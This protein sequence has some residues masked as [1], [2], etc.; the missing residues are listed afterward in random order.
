MYL[1]LLQYA[2]TVHGQ[3]DLG[4]LLIIPR[5]FVFLDDLLLSTP[6]MLGRVGRRQMPFDIGCTGDQ[7]D[8]VQVDDLSQ[9]SQPLPIRPATLGLIPSDEAQTLA[10]HIL[11]YEAKSWRVDQGEL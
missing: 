7:G 2:V 10:M 5:H 4:C 3:S 1:R 6:A 8:V 11:S 9:R